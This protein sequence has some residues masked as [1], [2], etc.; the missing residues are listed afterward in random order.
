MPYADL[1]DVR[2]YYE[3]EGTGPPLVLLNGSTG[4][5]ESAQ[6]GHWTT[7]RPYLAQHYRCIQ[8]DQR[9]T[10]RSSLPTGP[11]PYTYPALTQDAAGLI[12]H[13]GLTPAHVAGLSEGGVVALALAVGHPALLRSAIGIGANY[14]NDAKSRAEVPLLAPDHMERLS[15][16]WV[17]DLARRN[18]PY[19]GTGHWRTVLNW[20][21]AA[22]TDAPAFTVEDLRR[23]TVPTLWVVGEN[24]YF[25]ELEQPLTMKR[26]IPGAE[27]LIVNHAGHIAHRAHPHLVGPAM[28][29]FL[30]RVDAQQHE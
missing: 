18:D 8:Y 28:L 22:N 23:V 17:A 26:N 6:Q 2:L 7:L 14:M 1:P 5:L 25:F 10:G 21:V 16:G 15:P 19:H 12:E 13:L 4:T 30:T 27:L 11:N 29:D 3:E 24:E 9:G 20:I